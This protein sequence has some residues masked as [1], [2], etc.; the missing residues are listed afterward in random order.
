MTAT[1]TDATTQNCLPDFAIAKETT[2][3]VT[4]SAGARTYDDVK[5]LRSQSNWLAKMLANACSPARIETV[6]KEPIGF[7]PANATSF[8]LMK[9]AIAEQ[10]SVTTAQ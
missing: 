7:N 8:A 5:V 1:T 2:F 6:H 3:A 9:P 10:H 4:R